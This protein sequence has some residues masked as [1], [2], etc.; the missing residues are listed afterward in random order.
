[1]GNAVVM[2]TE[3][4]EKILRWIF[5][6]VLLMRLLFPFFN[7]PLDHLFSDPQRHWINGLN[8]L[9]P[10]LMGAKDPILYQLWMFALQHAGSGNSAI[11]LFGTGL[12]C[13][14]MPYG[15]YRALKELMPK[16]WAMGGAV[17]MGVVP[18]F[19][20]IYAY[21]M[22]ETLLLTLTGF[23]FWFTFR[24]WRLR[25]LGAFAL[26]CLFWLA[27]GF[28]RSVAL[29][30]GLICIA[31]LWLSQSRK[32]AKAIL[33]VVML[34]AFAV[35]AGLRAEA[36]LHYFAPFGNVYQETIYRVSGKK[37]IVLEFG[38]Q[39]RYNFGSPSYYNPTF[40]P[41]STWTT[42]RTGVATAHIDL[43]KGRA[44]W[45]NEQV[46]LA[47]ASDFPL[48][49]DYWENFLYLGFAQSW[50]DSNPKFL[51][52]WLTLWMRWLWLPLIMLVAYGAVRRHFK[53]RE[54][55]LPALALGM[56]GFF[57]VQRVGMM[58]GRYRKPIDPIYVASAVVLTWR[59]RLRQ[60][61]SAV[62]T[63]AAVV[64]PETHAA[65]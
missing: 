37:E 50:P 63:A 47:R 17:I 18:S 41:F 31:I 7:S 27:A 36:M 53:G 24:A 58:E 23:A 9:H 45:I 64:P 5:S 8:F 56:F 4:S 2:W 14:A 49:K 60:Y 57:M 10:D 33:G 40:Y 42:D 59:W 62:S 25:T 61:G 65:S 19:L 55:L 54:W 34:M 39:G 29:P 22:T 46:R 15:W 38:P 51:S 6:A 16:Q 3:R 12:L 20:G 26:A 43:N 13:A 30:M 1:M 28:T 11:I 32:I 35:P 52:G 48:W 44:D 21:F